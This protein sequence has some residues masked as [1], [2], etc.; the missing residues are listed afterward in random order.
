MWVK[1]KVKKVKK[2]LK[3]KVK[4]K[5]LKRFQVEQSPLR[6]LQLGSWEKFWKT[7]PRIFLILHIMKVHHKYRKLT[8]QDFSG[9][10]P[11]F[12]FWAFLAKNS[13][14]SKFKMNLN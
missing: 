6:T 5:V 12:R 9:K 8:K 7:A 4:K 13:Q 3:K 14:K 2:K 1:K 11:F 10:I